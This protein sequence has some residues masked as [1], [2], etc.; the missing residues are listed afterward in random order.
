MLR[1]SPLPVDRRRGLG[2]VHHYIGKNTEQIRR[3]RHGEVW[4]TVHIGSQF[5]NVLAVSKLVLHMEVG[6]NRNLDLHL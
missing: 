3:R 2:E 6:F 5:L 4:Y 1:R